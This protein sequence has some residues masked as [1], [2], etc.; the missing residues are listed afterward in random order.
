MADG[1][2]RVSHYN[3]IRRYGFISGDDGR[4]YFFHLSDVQAGQSVG[5]GDLVSFNATFADRGPRAR[6]VAACEEAPRFDKFIMTR[7]PEVR[8]HEVV[9]VI[10]EDI[11]Y[12][13]WDPNEAREGL[14]QRA[15]ALGANAIVGLWLDKYSKNTWPLALNIFSA[16]ITAGRITNNYYQ[17]MHRFH[18]RAVVVRRASGSGRQA[19]YTYSAP[20]SYEAT[21]AAPAAPASRMNRFAIVSLICGI[22]DLPF[23][24]FAFSAIFWMLGLI[25]GIVS[26]KQIDQRGQR[27][28]RLA[29]AGIVLCVLCG[30]S[31]LGRGMLTFGV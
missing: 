18:G 27:G 24:I 31:W 20:R 4:D 10:A 6:H 21:P 22:A 2:G 30:I 28:R 14:K 16:V 25:S 7:K 11:W 12:E 9:Q 17:T 5:R 13:T 8:G 26:L 15:S 1:R 3:S 29:I 23:Q 19:S